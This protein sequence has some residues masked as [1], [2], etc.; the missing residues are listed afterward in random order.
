M[1]RR[2]APYIVARVLR[3]RSAFIVEVEQSSNNTKYLLLLCAQ[4]ESVADS[5]SHSVVTG[6]IFRPIYSCHLLLLLL[7]L[8]V[9]N[10]PDVLQ[11]CG[12]LYYP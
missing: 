6:E 9:A 7:G 10:A 2:V 4:T 11:P 3:D 5:N 12:L 1:S 8:P